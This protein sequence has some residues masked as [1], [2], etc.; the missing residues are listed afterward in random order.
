MNDTTAAPAAPL[1]HGLSEA[2][3]NQIL[4]GARTIFLEDGFEGA[5]MDRIAKEA[6]V[7]KGTLYNYFQSKEVLFISLIQGDCMPAACECEQLGGNGDD[8]ATSLAEFGMQCVRR[9]LEPGEVALFRIV[10]A[11]A[12][13]FPELGRSIERHG[14]GN[15]VK[16]LSGYLSHL[17]EQ[18]KLNIPDPHL[19]AEQFMS[20]CD[21]GMVRRLQ[22][23]VETPTQEQISKQIRSAVALF[24]RGYAV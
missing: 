15:G 13:K 24:L 11:E 16:L 23:S 20:L 7:S 19:A 22:L 9:L 8:P 17:H 1:R 3:R 4:S 14:P 6:G 18:G 12:L 21:A 2:K 5:S 10:L